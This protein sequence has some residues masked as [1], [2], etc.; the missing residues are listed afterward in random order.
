MRWM[1]SLVIGVV[2]ILFTVAGAE[3]QSA[4][5]AKVGV[6]N[7]S[8]TVAAV[9]QKKKARKVQTARSRTKNLSTVQSASASQWVFPGSDVTFSDNGT[10]VAAWQKTAAVHTNVGPRPRAWCGW[11]MRTQRGGGPELNVAW[12]WSRWGRPASP[13]VGA[14]VVWR[15][16]VGEIVG[17]A[18]N[19]QWMVRSGNYGGAV[20]TRAMSVKGAV[21]RI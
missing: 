15:H 20:R 5:R 21:F 7:K 14:V 16:H 11:W 1:L 8:A 6:K 13:Q 2:A 17:Q 18:G 10:A 3:A 9:S 19:G 4:S 12:N